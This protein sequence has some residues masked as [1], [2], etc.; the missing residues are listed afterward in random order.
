MVDLIV[1]GDGVG[2][3]DGNP[4]ED[5]DEDDE[6]YNLEDIREDGFGLS[7]PLLLLPLI[8]S[9]LLLLFWLSL[10]EK[11]NFVPFPWFSWPSFRLLL[12]LALALNLTMALLLML[13]LLLLL[14]SP[15]IPNG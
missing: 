4:D 2:D 12:L 3:S 13:L 9:L 6:E 10:G 5:E 7:P 11:Y 15:K 1:E 14:G 8:F